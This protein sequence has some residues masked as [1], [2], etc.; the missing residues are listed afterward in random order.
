MPASSS[1]VVTSA[2]KR[3]VASRSSG[4]IAAYSCTACRTGS[5]SSGT[6]GVG[7]G[8]GTGGGVGSSGAA[9]SVRRGRGVGRCPSGSVGVTM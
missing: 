9:C 8:A 6:S 7:A 3:S 2:T 1:S 4:C 5:R